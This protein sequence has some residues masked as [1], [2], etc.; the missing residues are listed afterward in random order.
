[1]PWISSREWRYSSIHSNLGS[2][3]M[4]VNSL[5]SRGKGPRKHSEGNLVGPRTGL[6]AVAR[7]K[8]TNIWNR[9]PTPWRYRWSP[10]LTLWLVCPVAIMSGGVAPNLDESWWS[11]PAALAL[12]PSQYNLAYTPENVEVQLCAPSKLTFLEFL[13]S[14]V[15]HLTNHF[16]SSGPQTPLER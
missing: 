9:T 2:R 5:T 8:I 11:A 1:M 16:C 12:L 4:W 13:T 6:Q 15:L 10:S 3:S 14:A 7:R